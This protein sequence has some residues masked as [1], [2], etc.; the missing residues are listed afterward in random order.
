MAVSAVNRP[1]KT[2]AAGEAGSRNNVAYHPRLSAA[3]FK[4]PALT[5]MPRRSVLNAVAHETLMADIR[6]ACGLVVAAGCIGLGLAVGIHFDEILAD[7][8]LVAFNAEEPRWLW[9]IVDSL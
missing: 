8:R 7:V 6:L 2:P 9:T 4:P 3:A 5:P 1:L